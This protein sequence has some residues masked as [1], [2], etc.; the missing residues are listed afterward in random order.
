MNRSTMLWVLPA[1]GQTLT[2]WLPGVSISKRWAG[3]G[4]K[5]SPVEASDIR[6]P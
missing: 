2:T 6:R 5:R 3:L 1:P 4:L